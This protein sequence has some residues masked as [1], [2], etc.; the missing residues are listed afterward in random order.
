MKYP[1]TFITAIDEVSY[2]IKKAKA[3]LSD[4]RLTQLEKKILA[5]FMDLRKGELS[6][7]IEQFDQLKC[8]NEYL[9]SERLFCLGAAY[10]NSGD[11]LKAE[12]CLRDSLVQNMLPEAQHRKSAVTYLLFIVGSNSSNI[13]IMKEAL[14]AAERLPYVGSKHSDRLLLMYFFYAVFIQDVSKVKD[15]H[16]K[17]SERIDHLSEHQKVAF[18]LGYFEFL[19]ETGC[20]QEAR[21]Y[22]GKL[23][24]F[25]VFKCVY[26]M[27]VLRLMFSYL[28]DD[29]PFYFYEDLSERPMIDLQVKCLTSLQKGDSEEALKIWNI[30][31]TNYPKSY[32][33]GFKTIG[34]VSLFSLCVSKLMH[35]EV[36]PEIS[37]EA[38]SLQEKKLLDYL[39]D[40]KAPV[41][42]EELYSLL[43][44]TQPLDKTD[45][46]K[47]V[48]VIQRIRQK[49]QIEIQ[50]NLGC[51]RLASYKKAS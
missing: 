8:D 7:I 43:W 21:S 27:K 51:Y 20:I 41:K 24:D 22:L 48:K 49:T 46:R 34:R 11:Y 17:L 44:G 40:H 23:V 18:H 36:A 45:L 25:R 29:L 32:G 38:L 14:E 2:N 1:K 28:I 35:Q 47:L 12:A 5:G 16:L 10:N 4:K 13:T 39:L 42:Q 26:D 33:E 37:R 6:I 9:N 50:N 3:Y 30:L 15:L 19:I 31:K